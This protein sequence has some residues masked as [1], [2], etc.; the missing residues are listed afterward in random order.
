MSRLAKAL[1]LLSIAG[2]FTAKGGAQTGGL[3]L[4]PMR[5]EIEA[6]PGKPK[7]TSFMI[8]APP[9]DTDVRGRLIMSLTDWTIE[10]DTSMKYFDAGTHTAS[11]SSW[12]TFSPTDLTISSG[13]ERMVRVTANVP[14]GTPPG[15]YTSGIFVQERPPAKEPQ[16]GDQLLFFRFR[17]VV[18]LY[19]I[20]QPVTRQ[21]EAADF[22]LVTDAHGM[23]LTCQLQNTGTLH[24]RPYINWFVRSGQTELVSEKNVEATVLLPA[25]MAQESLPLLKP[26]PPG[27]YEIEAQVDFHDGRPIQVLKRSVE[28]SASADLN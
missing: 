1:L 23:R 16:K 12:I 21:G 2:A 5:L 14:V 27:Q 25:S 22:E 9:S 8:E 7:T 15:L 13:Q 24:L 10:P 4:R 26:L 20:V 18:T 17:Y 28:I 11:A 3:G 6:V 19:V